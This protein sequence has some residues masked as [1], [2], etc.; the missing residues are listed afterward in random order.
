MVDLIR[1]HVFETVVSGFLALVPMF[2]RRTM[3]VYDK[4]I[5]DIENHYDEILVKL[6]KIDKELTRAITIIEMGINK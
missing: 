3:G 4:R 5:N 6:H 1:N 2:I